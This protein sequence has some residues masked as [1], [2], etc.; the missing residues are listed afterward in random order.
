MISDGEALKLTTILLTGSAPFVYGE[1]QPTA[2][3]QDLKPWHDAGRIAMWFWGDDH[4]CALFERDDTKGSFIGSCIGHAGYPGDP[5]RADAKSFV[6]TQFV[7]TEKRFP[8][9]Y[10]LRDDLGNNG[11]VELSMLAD[12]GVEL[13]YVDWLGCKRHHASFRIDVQPNGGRLLTLAAR[14]SFTD[15]TRTFP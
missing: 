9:H 12:G 14:T 7:E 4:Y 3:Y 8:P 11:W 5:Q 6:K 13:L 2:L 10:Q 1:D 15:R